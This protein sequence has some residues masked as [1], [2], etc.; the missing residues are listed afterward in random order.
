MFL[1]VAIWCDPLSTIPVG[2]QL[3]SN[4][5]NVHRIKKIGVQISPAYPPIDVAR[6]GIEASPG[7]SV[8]ERISLPLELLFRDL[9]EWHLTLK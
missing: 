5:A 4:E 1:P 9:D 8:Y 2:K 6:R 3:P 7:R